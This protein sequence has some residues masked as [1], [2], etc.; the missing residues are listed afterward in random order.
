MAPPIQQN[1]LILKASGDLIRAGFADF[2]SDGDYNAATHEQRADVPY[3]AHVKGHNVTKDHHRWDGAAWVLIDDE[4]DQVKGQK[5]AQIDARTQELIGEGF[6][7]ASKQFSLSSNAQ[8]YW[9]GLVT[10]VNAGL[11]VNGAPHFPLTVNTVDD[12]DTHDIADVAEVLAVYGVSVATV[13]G[14][15]GSGTVIKDQ[16]RAAADVATV[17]AIVDNR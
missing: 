1:G 11:V 4:L 16:V 17:E 15:L 2:T 7:H 5:C 8:R 14:H 12:S 13:R 9:S 3:P 6:T 10:A